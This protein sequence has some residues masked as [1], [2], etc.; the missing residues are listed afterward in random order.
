MATQGPVV[1]MDI[2]ALSARLLEV[3]ELAPRA[4]LAA[5]AV[6]DLLPGSAANIYILGEQDAERVWIPQASVGEVSVTEAAV[7]LEQGALGTLAGTSAAVAISGK[8]LVREEYAHLHVR[9]TVQALAYAPLKAKGDLIGAIEIVSF[10]GELSSTSLAGLQPV[11]DVVGVALAS[12]SEYE[13]ERH[14]TLS[15]ITRLTQLYDIEKVLNSTLELDQLLPL[16]GSKFKELLECQALNVWLLEGDDSVTLMQQSGVDPTAHEGQT[17]KPGEGLAGDVSDNGE[18][19]L[20]ESAEDERLVTRNAG[21]EEGAIFSILL[22]PLIDRGS[23]VGVV[24]AVN[25]LEGTAFDEDDLFALTTFSETASSALHNASLLMAERKVEILEALV[26]TSG[27]ITSTLDLDRVLQAV[28]NGPAAVIPYER[29]AIALDDRGGTRLKAVSGTTQLNA[30]DPQYR[31]LREILQWS[32]VLSEPL[33]VAQHGEEVEADREETKAKFQQYFAETGMRACH[34][35]P[36]VDEEGRVGVL[37]FESSDP[38]FLAEAHLEMIK[39]LASQATVALRNASLYKEVPF[40]SVLQPLVERKKRFLALEKHKRAALVIGVTAVVVFLLAFPLPLRVDGNAVVAP[41]RIAHVGSEFEGVI[42]AVDVR[43]G[44]AVKKGAAIAEL[45]DWDYRSALA[46]AQAKHQTAV[47]AMDRALANSDGSEAGIQKAQADYWASEVMRAQDRLAKTII[48]SPIDGVIATPQ[49]ETLVG[50][51]LKEGD[52]FVDIVDNSEELV[53]VAIGE[54]DVALLKPGQKANLKLDG[55][56][57]RTFH[58]Q[59]AVVSPQ[60]VLQNAETTFFARVA[61]ANPDS[62]LRSGMQGRGKIST[63]WRPAG[64]VM[65]RRVGIWIWTKLWDWFGW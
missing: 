61:V 46:A 7:P 5:Q 60:G 3:R 28:V 63:G 43:E 51:K 20:I 45:E 4:R 59:V 42:K 2:A 24:E 13:Q 9:R 8:E 22:V 50:H 48:R 21:V 62:A 34:L 36:L 47:A 11:A 32:A 38:D 58:G 33:L 54:T 53:D 39:V 10:E 6:A 23:L 14:S 25:K 44:D 41:A 31:G 1:A 16:I 57:E 26:K 49:V 12:A 55:F 56:P 29:A 19:V 35:L 15:S 27:E 64:V 18:P 17:Q 40:I 52:S 65:F 30:D 37:L